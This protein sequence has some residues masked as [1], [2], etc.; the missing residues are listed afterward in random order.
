[1]ALLFRSSADSA[2]RW[3]EVLAAAM[4]DLET[5][6]WPEIGDPSDI[7]I[8]LVWKPPHGLLASLPNLKLVASLGAGV[9]HI[10]EDPALPAHVPVM[11]LVDPYM[12][13]AM[14]EY[15]VCQTLRLH[16]QDVTYAAQQRRNEWKEH[17]Q[18]N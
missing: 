1:M 6:F 5:R 9:D 18:P 15:V 7:E 4:P 14:T 10:F 11:R 8:A 2:R 16:R 17:F 12:V 3:R 13:R